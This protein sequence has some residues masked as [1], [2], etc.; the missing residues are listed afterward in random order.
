MLYFYA[1]KIKNYKKDLSHFFISYHSYHNAT[2]GE[3]RVL[4]LLISIKVNSLLF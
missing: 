4:S 3:F 2:I 1:V